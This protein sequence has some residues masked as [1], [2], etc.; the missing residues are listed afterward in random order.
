MPD[1]PAIRDVDH[2]EDLLSTPTP[3]VVASLGRR[4]GDLVVLGASGKMGPTLARMARRAFDQL[5]RSGDVIGVARFQDAA[6]RIRLE[7]FGVRTL[8]A[9]L[10]DPDAIANLPDASEVIYLVGTKF[11]TT[12]NEAATWAA[13]AFVPGLIARRYAG[14]R[15]VALSTGNVYGL[16][17]ADGPGSRETDAPNP[18]G[19]YAMSCLGRERVFE[20]F[21]RRDGTPIALIRLNYAVEPR[22]GVL[23]DIAQKVAD[24]ASVDLDV[25]FVNVIWQGD[26]NAQV[27]RALE[28]ADSPPRILN[29]T[30]PERLSV[31]AL[32]ESFGRALGRPPVFQGQ[33]GAS[34]LLSDA[35]EATRLFGPPRVAVET[36]VAWVADWLRRGGP[37]LG[38]PTRFEVSDGRF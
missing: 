36:V 20:H 25:G 6:A 13:N 16:V 32:A 30:G 28:H 37:T 23:L 11:G 38:K 19:E 10:S 1:P 5:G 24:G 21:S 17:P 18:S 22:Y 3:E 35:S 12:G 34:A 31:R 7:S 14:R 9:D 2:L 8:A 26:A 33:E 27:L 4:S 29:V 15:I